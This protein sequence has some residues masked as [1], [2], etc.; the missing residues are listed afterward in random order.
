MANIGTKIQELRKKKG[1][2]QAEMGEALGVSSQA[3]SRWENKVGA[4]DLESI[5]SIADYLG[6]TIDELFMHNAKTTSDK[7]AA[8][9]QDE[10]ASS[11]D[12]ALFEKSYLMCENIALGAVAQIKQ[13][14]DHLYRAGKYNAFALRDSGFVKLKKQDDIDFFFLLSERDGFKDRVARNAADLVAFFGVLS[15]KITFDILAFLYTRTA[16]PFTL[17]YIK[18]SLGLSAEEAE[19][20]ISAL[21]GA[22][23]IAASALETA[24]GIITVYSAALDA[25]FVGMLV[26]AIDLVG[27][28]G[29]YYARSRKRNKPFIH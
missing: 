3:V 10:I 5:P 19:R 25:A 9:L 18:K 11:K 26:F 21:V 1:V 8:A 27:Q 17:D 12:D 7:I 23:M 4:P 15:D 13:K 2:T 29:E 28:N 22:K 20:G 6:V 14:P 24:D 16:T